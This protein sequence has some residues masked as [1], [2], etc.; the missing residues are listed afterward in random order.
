MSLGRRHKNCKYICTQ[1]RN[2]SIYKANTNRHRRAAAKRS[3]PTSEVRGS[4]REYQNA[5]AQEWPIGA[6]PRLRSGAATRGVTP[7]LRSGAVTR[8]VTPH[9]RSGRAAGRKY[10]TPQARGQGQWRGRPTPHPRSYGCM[11]AGGPRGAIPRWRSG[12]VAVRRYPS[13][14]VRSNGCALLEQLWR[15]TPCPR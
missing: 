5:M 4:G 7:R 13:S 10:P 8:G 3:H 12:R 15:D 2:T 14:K 11:G 6:T 1:H 9:P